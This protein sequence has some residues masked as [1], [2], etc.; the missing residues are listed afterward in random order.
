MFAGEVSR[1]GTMKPHPI[2]IAIALAIASLTGCAKR[3]EVSHGASP[4]PAAMVRSP[5]VTISTERSL[6][7]TRGH[8]TMVELWST[9]CDPC[10]R[11]F[12]K[13]QALAD[14]YGDALDVVAIS[15]D[16][17]DAS[18]R[19]I[20]AFAEETHVRF[21]IVWDRARILEPRFHPTTLPTTYLLDPSGNVRFVHRG[22]EAGDDE[23]IAA[24][25]DA[26]VTSP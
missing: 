19:D 17:P 15:L 12:P 21:P 2:P 9:Y 14:R 20:A 5:R 6:D 11:A 18:E 16:D 10:R 1:E 25:L 26:L 8:W 13:Q 4:T 24:R 23:I 3:A 22:F 7:R